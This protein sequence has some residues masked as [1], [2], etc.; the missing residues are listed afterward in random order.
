MTTEPRVAFLFPGQGSLP[1]GLPPMSSLI[2]DLYAIALESNLNLKAW[3]QD[4]NR[5]RLTQ[6]DAAQPTILIDSMARDARLREAG[7]EPAFV[8]GHS[9]GEFSALAS[10][11]VLHTSDALDLVVARGAA[12]SGVEGTMAAIVKLDLQTVTAFCDA[13]GPDVVVANHNGAKQVVVSGLA[14][15]V[16]H[17]IDAAARAGGRGIPLRVSGPFHSPFMEPS[18]ETFVRILDQI[19]FHTPS[20]PVIC[21]V[22]GRPETG[23]ETLHNLMRVQMTSCVQWVDV[24]RQLVDEG[25]T[26]AI[27]VGAG[28]VLSNLGRR[29]TDEIRFIAYE[30][31]IHGTL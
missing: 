9:L 22:T 19:P 31:A 6:T 1:T 11:G 24:V 15:A 3:L 23:G 2:D 26:H 29:I 7:I 17:V 28:D 27:E 5:D 14:D 30:E 12:M 13:V 18:Q 10:S 25:V 16:G 21:A 4:D 8:A 20:C